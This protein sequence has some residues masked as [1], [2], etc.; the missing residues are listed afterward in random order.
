MKTILLPTDFSE[1]SWNAI[2]YTLHFFQKVKCNFYILH[3]EKTYTKPE[4]KQMRSLLSRIAKQFSN[5]EHV[6][7]TISDYDPFIDAVRKAIKKH[8]IDLIAMG[9]KGASGLEKILIGT[10]TADVL[11]KIECNTL[12]I[13]ENAKFTKPKDIVFPTDFLLPQKLKTL[14][15]ILDILEQFN[16]ALKM[17]YVKTDEGSLSDKQLWNKSLLK[18]FFKNY[19]SEIIQLTDKKV[20]HAVQF[21]VESREIDMIALV[22]KKLNYFQQLFFQTTT[23]AIGYQTEIPFLVLHET[24]D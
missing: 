15:P 20:S 13:P 6:F 7:S 1:N 4:I 21:F 3:V 16:S 22:T 12:V 18:D 9:T 2:V 17:L 5:K 19:D 24:I 10:N 14:E 11:T 8:N 23:E